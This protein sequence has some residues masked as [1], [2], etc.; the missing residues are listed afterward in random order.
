[1]V[2][3]LLALEGDRRIDVHAD[4]ELAF[5]WACSGGHL[6]VVRLLLALEG[7]RRIDVHS[8]NELA[9]R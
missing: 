6:K 3:L 4:D 1:M 9:F 8:D 5:G 7:D 2:R